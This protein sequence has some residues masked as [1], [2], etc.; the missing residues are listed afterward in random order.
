M[1]VGIRITQPGEPDWH[2][3]SAYFTM[4]ARS[5][6]EARSLTLAPLELR[7]DLDRRRA[8][9]ALRRR[10][11]QRAEDAAAHGPPSPEEYELLA[12]LHEAQE[13]DDFDGK[14]ASAYVIESWER[15][16]PEQ[17]NVPR[18]I[19]GGYL[20]RR[21]YELCSIAARRLVPDRPLIARV[22]RINFFHPVRLGDTLHFTAGV[23]YAG[24]TSVS[25]ET[26][27]ERLSRDRTAHALSNSC[28][29]T[30]LNV[31]PELVP[32]PVPAIHP[33]TFQ[34]DARWLRALRRNRALGPHPLTGA[35]LV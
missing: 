21:A 29:F 10:E 14:L 24:A 11:L 3:G 26:S 35:P 30:F 18:T 22:D 5:T 15:M 6:E 13:R 23:V 19:F 4:V 32:R 17:E 31:D 33:A 27:I 12:R 28:M 34:E 2:V 8:E 25:V 7:D 9:K 16:Y 20:M 1:E